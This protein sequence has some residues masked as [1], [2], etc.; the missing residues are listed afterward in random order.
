MSGGER[1]QSQYGAPYQSSGSGRPAPGQPLG[2][3]SQEQYSHTAPSPSRSGMAAQPSARPYLSDYQYSYQPPQYQSQLQYPSSYLQDPSRSHQL[4]PNPGQQQYAAYGHGAILPPVGQQSM[5]ESMPQYQQ[6]RHSAAI[7]V[8]ASQFGGGELPP[9][10]QQSESSTPV[11]PSSQYLSSQPEQ[12]YGSMSY[13]RPQLQPPFTPSSADYSILEQPIP[14]QTQEETNARQVTEEGRR[15]YE[16]QLRAIF[17][18]ITAG[19]VTEAST[20][21]IAITE[22]LVGSVRALSLHHDDEE[23]HEQRIQIWRE[24][25]HAWEALGYRQKSITENA[26]RAHQAPPDLLSA[27]KIQDLVDQLIQLCD[28]IEKYGLV[29]YEMGIWEEQIV[30]VFTQCLDILPRAPARADSGS[31]ER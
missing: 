12:Q 20:K 11:P 7:E 14:Q 8:M 4:Q 24:L 6:Q 22:W 17:D 23:S 27:A 9:Y 28:Q 31:A 29:D 10:M 25:N 16:Q 1:R 30:A 5:Y 21:L 15:Q 2:P 13:S 3:P 19:R 26:L 18:A